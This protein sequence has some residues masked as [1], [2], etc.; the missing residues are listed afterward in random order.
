MDTN[1][2]VPAWDSLPRTR[3]NQDVL[4]ETGEGSRQLQV[5]IPQEDFHFTA[6]FLID[7]DKGSGYKNKRLCKGVSWARLDN[8]IYIPLK[9]LF[10]FNA[11]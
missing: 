4:S 3:N 11:Q 8:L 9:T 2:T 6:L 10:I 1:G 7:S 5:V